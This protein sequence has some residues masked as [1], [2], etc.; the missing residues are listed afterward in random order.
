[1]NELT[2]LRE[3]FT[4]GHTLLV[5]LGVGYIYLSYRVLLWYEGRQ[6]KRK[7]KRKP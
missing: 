7:R 6:D 3:F 5:I 4:I 2:A 1:M